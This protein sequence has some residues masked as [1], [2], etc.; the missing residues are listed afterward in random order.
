MKRYEDGKLNGK[1]FAPEIVLKN[2]VCD[3]LLL[4]AAKIEPDENVMAREESKE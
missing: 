2:N 4:V 3:P 1:L